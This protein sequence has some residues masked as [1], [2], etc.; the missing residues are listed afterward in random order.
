MA[1]IYVYCIDDR[2]GLTFFG[3]RQSRDSVLIQRLVSLAEGKRIF[4]H[5]FSQKLFEGY[6]VV[7]DENFLSMAKAG[8]YCFIENVDADL[9]RAEEVI[10]YR[11]NRHYPSDR[12]LDVAAIEKG[13][14][15]FQ[16]SEFVG[17]SHEKITEEIYKKEG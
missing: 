5:P 12:K 17:K 14:R 1:M 13:Y 11:W 9:S 10:L 4:I 6:S 15:L 3:K 2:N 16:T 7:C 8:D